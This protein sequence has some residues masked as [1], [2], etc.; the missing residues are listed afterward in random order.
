MKNT[1]KKNTALMMAVMLA[2]CTSA[3]S[4]SV[5]ASE[6]ADRGDI[7]EKYGEP[8]EHQNRP[9]AYEN[10]FIQDMEKIISEAGSIDSTQ[11]WTVTENT[12]IKLRLFSVD[13]SEIMVLTYEVMPAGF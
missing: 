7:T 2:G 12:E 5:P 3:S 13:D 8:A 11:Y 1:V 4:S 6:T 10:L 9:A